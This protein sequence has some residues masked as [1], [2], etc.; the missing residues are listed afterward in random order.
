MGSQT[1]KALP[2]S[3]LFEVVG[4]RSKMAGISHTNYN[5]GVLRLVELVWTGL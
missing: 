4:L 1:G 3:M 2:D 5:F